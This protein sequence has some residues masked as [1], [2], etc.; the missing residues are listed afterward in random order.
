MQLLD[1]TIKEIQRLNQLGEGMLQSTSLQLRSFLIRNQINLE[2]KAVRDVTLPN[3]KIVPRRTTI[4]FNTSPLLI[5]DFYERPDQF[6]DYRCVKLREEGGKWARA[7]SGLSIP[8]FQRSR[9]YSPRICP[10]TIGECSWDIFRRLFDMVL[11]L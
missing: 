4:S 1:S 5:P 9:L 10:C 7:S 2:R 8:P 3:G 6:D 11:R